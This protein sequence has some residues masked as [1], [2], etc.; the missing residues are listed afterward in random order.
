MRMRNVGTIIIA[1][2]LAASFATTALTVSAGAAPKE[3]ESDRRSLDS[4]RSQ[5]PGTN[6]CQAHAPRNIQVGPRPFYLIDTMDDSSLK[7]SLQACEENTLHSTRFSIGHR[8][9]A[10]QFPE[11]T[12]ESLEAAARMGA[13]ILECD[14]TFTKDRQLVCR[15][16]Q[17]DLHTTTNILAIPE[18]AAKCSVP[19]SPANTTTGAPATA[20]CC[21]SDITL[22]EFKSLCGKMDGSTPKATTVAEYLDGTPSFRTDTYATCGSVLSHR[23]YISLVSDLGAEFTPELKAASVSMPFGGDYT[24]ERYAQ[25]MLDEYKAAH[26]SP[27]RVFAQSF[28]LNDIVYWVAHEPDFAKQ[29]VYLDD[30][31]D[32]A[33]GFDAAVARLATLPAKGVRIVAPPT[34]ALVTLDANKRIVPSSYAIAAKAA[35]L[36]I[37]TWTLERSGP[38]ATTGRSDYYYQSVTDAIHNDGDTFVLLDVLARKVGIRGIFSDWPGTV[39]YYANCMGL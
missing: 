8:G 17:C 25:Q 24:Q 7:R 13:G 9:A 10:L 23:E 18:L 37:I 2:P 26:I 34:W 21:T 39:T 3:K 22:A 29:A 31:V 19:F 14:V 6:Q 35:G 4:Y 28:N 33:G 36:D 32:V 20:R 15:H 30:Q 27:H 16:S 11:E 12:R 38:L 5:H 1:L